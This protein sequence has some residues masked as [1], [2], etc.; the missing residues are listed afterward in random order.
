MIET[1]GETAQNWGNKIRRAEEKGELRVISKG[2]PIEEI[3]ESVRKISESFE[4]MKRSGI[5]KDVLYTYLRGKGI[6]KTAIEDV[7]YHQ[8]QFFRS[9]RLLK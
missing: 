1:Q 9:L 8:D 3:K 7:L 6:T 4:L 5:T 2:D